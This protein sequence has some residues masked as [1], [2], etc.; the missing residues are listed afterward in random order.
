MDELERLL[1]REPHRVDVRRRRQAH[2]VSHAVDDI[3]RAGAGAAGAMHVGRI[4]EHVVELLRT[5][6][7]SSMART[8]GRCDA[9]RR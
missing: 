1:A 3:T 9:Q 6:S 7:R 2:L 8:L 4:A 5:C